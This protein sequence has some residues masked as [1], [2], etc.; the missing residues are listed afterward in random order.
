MADMK[1]FKPIDIW[2]RVGGQTGVGGGLGTE[3]ETVALLQEFAGAGPALELGIGSGRIARPLAATGVRVDGIDFFPAMLGALRREPGGDQIST[4]M[5]DMSDFTLPEKN[6][7]LIYCV[8]NSFN[9]VVSQD[10][11]VQVFE[12]VAR[13]LDD[14]GFFV[15]ETEVDLKFFERFSDGQYVEAERLQADRVK[16]DVVRIDPATQL[17]YE[18]HVTL[19]KDGLDFGPFVH[20]WAWPS[21]L[22]LMARLAGLRLKHRW[23]SWHREPY[24][25]ASSNVISVFARP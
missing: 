12:N 21:E 2:E 19:T 13:H 17:L 16:L 18:N 1:D 5:S 4:T 22:D 20:R 14:E 6:Y 15:L 10:G 8:F 3:P 9:N 11:Q 23:G 24:T 7:R 25:A